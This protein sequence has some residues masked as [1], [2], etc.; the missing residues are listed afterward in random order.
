[1]SVEDDWPVLCV[2]SRLGLGIFVVNATA[3]QCVVA[4]QHLYAEEIRL[5]QAGTRRE[6]VGMKE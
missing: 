2:S 5:F 1:M 3:L 6:Y 4:T